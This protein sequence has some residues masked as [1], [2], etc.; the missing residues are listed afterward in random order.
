MQIRPEGK[1]SA[2]CK[3]FSDAD[4]VVPSTTGPPHPRCLSRV[5]WERI[6]A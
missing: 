1:S 5:I 4:S 2:G 3:D 6:D